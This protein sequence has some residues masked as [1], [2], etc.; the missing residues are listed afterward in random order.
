MSGLTYMF[1]VRL[2]FGT[3]ILCS[4]A[5]CS[6]SPLQTSLPSSMRVASSEISR[7]ER[8]KTLSSDILSQIALERVTGQRPQ[9]MTLVQLAVERTN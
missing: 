8:P 1:V 9:D 2:I 4:L 5:A 6:A 3:A 7:G